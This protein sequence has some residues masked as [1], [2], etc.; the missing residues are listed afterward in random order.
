MPAILRSGRVCESRADVACILRS[1]KTHWATVNDIKQTDVRIS[2]G[3]DLL[4]S[5]KPR[6]TL[7]AVIISEGGHRLAASRSLLEQTGFS[8]VHLPAVLTNETHSTRH[9]RNGRLHNTSCGALDGFRLAMRNAWQLVTVTNVS[10]A[11]FEDDVCLPGAALAAANLSLSSVREHIC[12]F[13]TR[14]AD[15]DLA[16]LGYV[17]SHSFR[18]ATHATWVTPR[19]ARY[20][21]RHSRECTKPNDNI[22][23]DKVL[24]HGCHLPNRKLNCAYLSSF[25]ARVDSHN[26]RLHFYGIFHQDRKKLESYRVRD[27]R[28]GRSIMNATA[29]ATQEP[30]QAAPTRAAA[31]P[32]E[33]VRMCSE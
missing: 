31:G 16:Y 24:A 22:L 11:I 30:E 5:G 17:R 8:V 20:L 2:Y 33:V 12:S 14:F 10:M 18:W 23:A 9:G 3:T 6:T 7:P 25:K 13:L 21:L 19:A 28:L 27:D 15:R 1:K 32:R 29:S 4:C 26:G